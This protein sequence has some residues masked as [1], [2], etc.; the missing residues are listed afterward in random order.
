M[1]FFSGL[2]SDRV[3]RDAALVRYAHLAAAQI[4]QFMNLDDFSET[5]TSHGGLTSSGHCPCNQVASVAPSCGCV[6]LLKLASPKQSNIR[7]DYCFPIKLGATGR[8]FMSRPQL[9][10]F[11]L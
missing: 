7:L 2:P 9:C 11:V 5:S 3:Q 6:F 1:L 10:C 4:S 8:L